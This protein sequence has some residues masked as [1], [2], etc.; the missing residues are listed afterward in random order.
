MPLHEEC[1]AL[2][3]RLLKWFVEI[4]N[5]VVAANRSGA[6]SVHVSAQ[7]VLV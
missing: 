4:V 7:Y 1:A 2:K 6:L 5:A 3:V